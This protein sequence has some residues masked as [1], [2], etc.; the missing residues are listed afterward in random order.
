MRSINSVNVADAA[1]IGDS[2]YEVSGSSAS[3]S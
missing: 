2:L 3:S 1:G